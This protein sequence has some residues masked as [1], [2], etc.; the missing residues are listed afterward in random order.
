MKSNWSRGLIALVIAIIG[1][2]VYFVYRQLNAHPQLKES[3]YATAAGPEIPARPTTTPG[4]A[5]PTNS[6]H[7]MHIGRKDLSAEQF[8]AFKAKF[9]QRLKPVI[10][11]WVK[12]YDGHIPFK[13]ENLTADN[14]WG[15]ISAGRYNMYTFMVDGV[16]VCVEDARGEIRF[17]YISAPESQKLAQLPRG[18]M[19]NPAMPVTRDDVIQMLKSDSGIAFAPADIRMTP[20]GY[21]T[22]INGGAIIEVGGDPNNAAS[23]KYNLVF[24]PNGNLNYYQKGR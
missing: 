20:T 17:A 9:E 5:F 12:A 21:G 4:K 8:A 11:K 15:Q 19:P 1:V 16:T 18:E 22:A 10:A 2:G 3:P 24:G 13:A 14:L 23:W 7:V 6:S